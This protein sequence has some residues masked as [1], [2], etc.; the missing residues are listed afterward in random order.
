M[1]RQRWT[2]AAVILGITVLSAGMNPS[3][4]QADRDRLRG[5]VGLYY[6]ELSP[7]GD[8]VDDT[9]YGSAWSPRNVGSD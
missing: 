7:Y 1:N 8:W 6:D 4:A 5:E 3:P 2:F 9:E